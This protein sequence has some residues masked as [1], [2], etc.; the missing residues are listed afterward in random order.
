MEQGVLPK[1]A[2]GAAAD[3]PAE[4]PKAA[5]AARVRA[6]PE[7]GPDLSM[8]KMTTEDLHLALQI[9][10]AETKNKQLEVK[11]CISAS[12]LLSWKEEPP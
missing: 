10:E 3:A 5:E 2:V 8:D 4:E 9:K 7:L 11:P 1:L 6:Q 12:G